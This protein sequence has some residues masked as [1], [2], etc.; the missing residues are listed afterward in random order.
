MWRLATDCTWPVSNEECMVLRDF[1]VAALLIGLTGW[2]QAASGGSPQ[3]A[4]AKA[5]N[6]SQSAQNGGAA[7]NAS[8]QDAG[9]A[10]SAGQQGAS[11]NELARSTVQNELKAIDE[12]HTH[13][14][15]RLETHKSGTT[16]TKE[17]VET[18]HGN[19]M[20][21]VA[22]NGQP[23]SPEEQKKEDQN[24]QK[25]VSDP[26]AQQKQRQDLDQDEH[27]TRDLLAMLPEALTYTY[28]GREG[29]R[30]K[31]NFEPNPN[32]HPPSREARVFNAMQ[33]EM[34]IDTKEHRLVEFSGH[35]MHPVK[36][37]GGLLGDLAAGGSF[38]VR[39][40]EVG[41]EHWEISLLKVNMNGKALFFKTI[42]VHQDERHSD[43]KRVPDELT[44]A[45]AEDLV[46]K[47]Q[48]S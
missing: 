29:N 15:Y 6:A 2:F 42:S 10:L 22:R 24:V 20:R 35:L 31:L 7:Q 39:Q 17:V 12:D 48:A 19:V 21:L 41:P 23:L 25:F 38:D 13:W 5:P 3:A 4:P 14:M 16:E 8:L 26:G 1:I 30:T 11:A 9:A 47:Q 43:F 33:G 27:K 44:L 45:Q 18:P 32:F 40:Q 28:A 46:S 36:F 37:G 34:V